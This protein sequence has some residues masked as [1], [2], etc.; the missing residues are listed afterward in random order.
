MAALIPRS[1]AERVDGSSTQRS[2]G[3][4]TPGYTRTSSRSGKGNRFRTAD[5]D[6]DETR[7]DGEF[8]D[9]DSQTAV[10]EVNKDQS[11]ERETRPEAVLR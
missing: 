4:N 7:L 11:T 1:W 5:I 2:R 10:Y 3:R 9:S 6:L 8:N